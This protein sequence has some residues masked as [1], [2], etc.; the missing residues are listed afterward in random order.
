MSRGMDTHKKP[1]MA[2]DTLCPTL[3]F[4]LMDNLPSLDPGTAPSGSGILARKY[5]Y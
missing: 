4:L 3:S 5:N 2:M 1:F